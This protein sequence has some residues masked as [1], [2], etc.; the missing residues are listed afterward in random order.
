MLKLLVIHEMVLLPWHLR[1][2]LLIL[3]VML[4]I[5]ENLLLLNSSR[6][7]VLKL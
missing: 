3:F 2:L 5:L 1:N 6:L 4:V 7:L